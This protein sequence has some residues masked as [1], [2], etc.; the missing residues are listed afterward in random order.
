[1]NRIVSAKTKEPSTPPLRIH[2]ESLLFSVPVTRSTPRTP[3]RKVRSS[4]RT[5]EKGS[6]SA[7]GHVSLKYQF[8]S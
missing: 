6:A 8:Y 3:E 4:I 7:L 1:M 5:M 2:M